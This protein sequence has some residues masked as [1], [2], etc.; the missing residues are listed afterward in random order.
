MSTALLCSISFRD[1]IFLFVQA[2]QGSNLPVLN[3]L[4]APPH[5]AIG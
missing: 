3:F 2:G 1:F 4:W 5:P